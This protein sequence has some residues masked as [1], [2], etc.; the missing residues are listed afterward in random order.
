MMRGVK[1]TGLGPG[2]LL[3]IAASIGCLGHGAGGRGEAREAGTG[4]GLS[5][6]IEEMK[7]PAGHHLFMEV[8][9]EGDQIYTCTSTPAGLAWVFTAPEA[10]LRAR[11]GPVAG[12]H[13]AGPT[14]EG[15][16][17]SQVVGAKVAGASPDPG[18]IPW[19]LLRAASHRGKGKMETVTYIQRLGT[20][21]GVAPGG[22]CDGPSVGQ[23]ARVPYAATYCFFEAR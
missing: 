18:A 12:H 19:L 16:D 20:R 14:W 9:A 1:T 17:G 21:G 8:Q 5:L 6:P 3:M 7:P 15:L 22:G 13:S 4:C 23:V 2:W 11:G 10:V